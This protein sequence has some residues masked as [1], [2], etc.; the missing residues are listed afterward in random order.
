MKKA[1]RPHIPRT[2]RP[3][4]NGQPFFQPFSIRTFLGKTTTPMVLSDLEGF[5]KAGLPT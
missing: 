2:A 1:L 4:L 3:F 5:Y